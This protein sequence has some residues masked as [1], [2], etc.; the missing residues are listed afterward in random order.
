[1]RKNLYAIVAATALSL[2]MIGLTGCFDEPTRWG[3]SRQAHEER[4]FRYGP[5]HEVC[6]ANGNHCMV[7]D[8]DNDYCRRQPS[9]Y[10]YGDYGY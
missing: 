5:K 3:P 10:G 1:M 8:T 7:C 4:E 9:G 6:D 2:G